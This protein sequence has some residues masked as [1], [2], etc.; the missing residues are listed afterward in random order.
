MDTLIPMATP[1]STILSLPDSGER[2]DFIQMSRSKNLAS[3]ANL[4][5]PADR[6]SVV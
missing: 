3:D 2:A 4:S 6:K 1:T 5:N